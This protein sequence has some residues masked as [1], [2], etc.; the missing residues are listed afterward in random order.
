MGP[1]IKMTMISSN[2]RPLAQKAPNQIDKRAPWMPKSEEGHFYVEGEVILK[3]RSMMTL[4]SKKS[5]EM[6]TMSHKIAFSKLI[7]RVFLG[8]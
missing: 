2:H 5:L 1:N 7:I 6:R 4:Y 3:I 8:I